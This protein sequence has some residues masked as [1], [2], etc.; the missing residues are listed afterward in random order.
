MATEEGLARSIGCL[1]TVFPEFLAREIAR[2]TDEVV[3]ASQAITDPLAAV[4]DTNVQGIVDDAASLSEGA[5]TNGIASTSVG[6]VGSYLKREARDRIEAMAMAY[7]GAIKKIQEAQNVAE[8]VVANAMLMFTVYREAP[9][10]VAQKM[11]ERIATLADR[12]VEQLQCLKKHIIQMSNCVSVMAKAKNQI[13]DFPAELALLSSELDDA[14]RE[15]RVSLVRRPSGT[16]IDELALERAVDALTNAEKILDPVGSDVNLLDVTK[17][18][19]SGTAS[20]DHITP[21]NIKLAAMMLPHLSYLLEAETSAVFNITNAINFQLI[22]LS[23]I[24]ND[25]SSSATSSRTG[26][27]RARVVSDILARVELLKS[28]VDK[29]IESRSTENQ[30]RLSLLWSSSLKSLVS[31]GIKIQN[32][33]FEAGSSEGTTKFEEMQDGYDELI[34]RLGTINSDNVV[35]GVDDVAD[36]VTQVTNLRK[37]GSKLMKIIDERDPTDADMLNFTILVAEVATGGGNRI[38]ESISAALGIREACEEFASIEIGFRRDYD[39]LIK[40]FEALG[41]DRA[42]DLLDGGRFSEFFSS[43]IDG[44]SY[45][46]T[47]VSCLTQAINGVDD[48]GTR[49]EIAALRDELQSRRSNELLSAADNLNYGGTKILDRARAELESFQKKEETAKNLVK[50]LQDLAKRL[51][52]QFDA[53]SDSFDEFRGNL[54]RLEIDANARLTAD[55]NEFIRRPG[56]GV[57][58]C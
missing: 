14:R 15:L 6:L 54:D 28:D 12:K 51:D 52:F 45:I 30:T 10:A 58:I 38:D 5:I 29:A 33:S 35:S 1:S 25:F 17:I 27:I 55:F 47:A 23:D 40:T 16:V 44:M 41:F 11:C 49:S 3:S 2:L 8:Q 21:A 43:T 46:S 39:R 7:P 57:P 19:T 24:L 48:V 31:M 13:V 18:L 20:S 37:S 32:T 42:S 36:L 4:A 56:A 26:D 34:R 9:F 22:G 53:V 50:K